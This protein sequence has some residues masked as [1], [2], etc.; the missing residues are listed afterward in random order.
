MPLHI[1]FSEGESVVVTSLGWSFLTGVA[2]FCPTCGQV[3]MSVSNGAAESWYSVRSPC[4]S[5]GG[6]LFPSFNWYAGEWGRDMLLSQEPSLLRREFEAALS[7]AES[8]G[9][10][11]PT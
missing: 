4:L 8:Q 9:G 7:W 3:W 10:D 1:R 6:T 5:H 11:T 2:M